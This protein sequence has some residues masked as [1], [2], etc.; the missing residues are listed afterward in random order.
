MPK[1][2]VYL[3]VGS[4]RTFAGAVEWPGWCRSGRD[5]ASALQALLEYAP[6]YAAAVGS[7]AGFEPPP[8]VEALT[9]V[10]RLP[11]DSTT[12]FGAPGAIPEVDRRAPDDADL[13]RLEAIFRACWKTF[14]KAVKAANGRELRKGPRGGG[15]DVPGIEEHVRGAEAAYAAQVGLR[16]DLV[17]AARARAAGELPD[18]GPRGGERW[19][20]RYAIRRAAW[21]VLDHAWEIED[22]S[23]SQG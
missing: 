21:H 16:G 11:G 10:E 9:V 19:P 22:R 17:K 15:R 6:R 20:A 23:T 13:D 3:E 14:D 2:A 1:T 18:R 8:D 12:D 7:D 4:K 5:E